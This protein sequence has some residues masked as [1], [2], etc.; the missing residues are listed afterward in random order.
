MSRLLRVLR[1][2]SGFSLVELLTV[3]VMLAVV[4]AG[5]TTLFV[6]GSNGELDLNRRFQAQEGARVALDKLRREVHCSS[7]ITPTGAATSVA[8][9]LAASCPTSGGSAITANWCALQVPG[10]PTGQYGLYRQTGASCTTAGTQYADYLTS[11]AV[12]NYSAPDASY[13]GTLRVDLQVNTKPSMAQE[14]FELKD[15]LVLRNT[16]RTGASTTAPTC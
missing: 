16:V 3:M 8:L 7:A 2:E 9:T 4:V 13:L 11:S 14:T 10:A 15:C 6:Q 12:F 1:C 5:L